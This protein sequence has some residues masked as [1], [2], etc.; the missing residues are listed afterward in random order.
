MAKEFACCFCLASVLI[1]GLED[2]GF[3]ARILGAEGVTF[4]GHAFP[5]LASGTSAAVIVGQQ[6][7]ITCL[8]LSDLV[9]NRN[10]GAST[11]VPEDFWVGSQS[12]EATFRDAADK[13]ISMADAC[14]VY[15]D[16]QL[17]WVELGRVL[18]EGRRLVVAPDGVWPRWVTVRVDVWCIGDNRGERLGHIWTSHD[19]SVEQSV[20]L[21]WKNR[22]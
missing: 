10:N 8:G 4:A 19:G 7:P 11:F 9:A 18:W 22:P 16:E 15:L 3:A 5:E 6:Y 14:G 2:G 17:V 20:G 13:D 21:L 1:L 12:W